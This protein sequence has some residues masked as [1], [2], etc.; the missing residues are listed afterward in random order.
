MFSSQ[1]LEYQ[2]M[3]PKGQGGTFQ[4][5]E[6]IRATWPYDLTKRPLNRVWEN[7][8]AYAK[9]ERREPGYQGEMF[10]MRQTHSHWLKALPSNHYHRTK[11][12]HSQPNTI[13]NGWP[14][15]S[16]AIFEEYDA[17]TNR[18][19]TKKGLANI[20]S[21]LS[22][23]PTRRSGVTPRFKSFQK[24]WEQG[25]RRYETPFFA[26]FGGRT[27]G[28]AF[29]QRYFVASKNTFEGGISYRLWQK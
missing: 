9:S 18:Y 8:D 6:C 2:H 16:I 25:I 12:K 21:S 24:W 26:V 3:N 28:Q 7:M 17:L 27:N 19:E 23:S 1:L 10:F 5:Y 14:L 13:I 11:G 4:R 15:C 29:L 22:G 20:S